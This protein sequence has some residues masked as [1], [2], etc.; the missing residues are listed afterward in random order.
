LKKDWK[1]PIYAFFKPIPN[2]GHENGRRYHEFICAAHGCL[3]KIR[4]FLDK[5]DAKSTGNMRKHVKLCWGADAIDAADGTKNATEAHNTVIKPL[6]RDGSISA[7]FKRI[8]MEKV[9]Y[10]H[11]QHTKVETKCV[12]FYITNYE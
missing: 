10:S 2:I 5:K 12:C 3:K 9:T 4:R 8:G 7:V 11:R 1:A 6:T